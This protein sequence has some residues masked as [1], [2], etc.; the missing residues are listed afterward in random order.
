MGSLVAWRTPSL[1]QTRTFLAPVCRQMALTANNWPSPRH[2]TRGLRSSQAAAGCTSYE[3]MFTSLSLLSVILDTF[4]FVGKISF[5]ELNTD[6]ELP[7][8]CLFPLGAMELSLLLSPTHRDKPPCK[9]QTYS[10]ILIIQALIYTFLKSSH[11]LF[12]GCVWSHC[13]FTEVI[14]VDSNLSDRLKIF[15]HHDDCFLTC[16]ENSVLDSFTYKTEHYHL[17]NVDWNI[18]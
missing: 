10:C 11:G 18:Q 15:G 12:C 13:T 1:F 5:L 16:E 14:L 9:A 2:V 4:L 17:E 7:L 3:R 6:L 8:C